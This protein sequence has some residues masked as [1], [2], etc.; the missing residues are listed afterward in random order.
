MKNEVDGYTHYILK[1]LAT[2][3]KLIVYTLVFFAVIFGL[4]LVFQYL[5]PFIIA[6][7]ISFLIKPIAKMFYPLKIG[8]G[9]SVAISMLLVY[10]VFFALLTLGLSRGISELIYLTSRLPLYS[11]AIYQ[12]ITDLSREAQSIYIQ[13]P[14]EVTTYAIETAKNLLDKLGVVLTNTVR[15]TIN[16][17]Y[18]LPKLGIIFIITSVAAF[19]FTKDSDK[20]ED[21]I[22]RQFTPGWRSKLINF[23]KNLLTSLVGFLKAQLILITITFMESL[24]GLNLIGVKYALTISILVSLV[25]VLPVL[26][27][28]SVYVPWA[29]ISIIIGKYKLGISLLVLYAVIVVIR[30]MIEPKVVGQQLGIHPLISLI[31]IYAGAK[32]MGPIGVILGPTIAVTIKATQNVGMLPKFK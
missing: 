12:F 16:T 26:G 21:F 17:L 32:I 2:L 24:I 6:I 7:L 19:F 9:I 22:F 1:T 30:Y 3:L 23:K 20:I 27:T 15:H 29:I 11:D 25:D 5:S 13:L 14:S 8:K 28:G 4:K 31:S 10:G 18:T